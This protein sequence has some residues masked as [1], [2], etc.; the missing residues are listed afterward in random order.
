MMEEIAH[1]GITIDKC[2]GCQGLWFDMLEQDELKKL[3]AAYAV[4]TGDKSIGK[5][6]NAKED[7]DCPKCAGAKM[8][9]MVDI[10]QSHI[11]YEACSKCYGVFFD[12]GEF[13]DFAQEDL[14]DRVKSMLKKPRD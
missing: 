4:D 6:F 13:K 2:S 5:E 10:A 9:K 1:Q 7:Y 14:F 8:V 11:W 3:A 12:A